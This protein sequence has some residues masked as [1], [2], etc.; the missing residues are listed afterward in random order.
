MSSDDA[1]PQAEHVEYDL[2]V[3]VHTVKVRVNNKPD[4]WEPGWNGGQW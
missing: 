4:E 2:P 1:E 3:P